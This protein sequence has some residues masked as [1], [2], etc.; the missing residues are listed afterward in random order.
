MPAQRRSNG[1]RR[2]RVLEHRRDW[3]GEP[4]YRR[5]AALIRRAVE[6][7]LADPENVTPDLHGRLSTKE[8]TDR[9]LG[10]L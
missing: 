6:T 1:I 2:E 3:F 10:A 7:V 4:E 8:L 5:G 9:I